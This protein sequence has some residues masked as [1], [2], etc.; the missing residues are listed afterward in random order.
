MIPAVSVAPMMDRTDRHFRWMMRQIAPRVL[1]WS[2]MV[3]TGAVLHGDREK[4]LGHAP[5]EGPVVLQLGGDDPRALAEAAR[6]GVD[7]GYDEI[8]LNCGCPSDRVQQGAF[9]AVL[10]KTPE[11]VAEAV[12]AM[13]AAVD[14]PVTVKHRIGVD[15]VD[16]YA[17]MLHFVDTVAAAG[18]TRFTVHARKAWLQGLSPK[19]NRTIPPL[20]HA[21]VHRLKAERPALWIETNGGVRTTSEAREHLAHVDAV[22]I[23]RGAVDVPWWIGELDAEL[24]DGPGPAPV[25]HRAELVERA[26]VYAEA[27]VARGEPHHRLTRHLL[28]LF[29]GQPGAR[30]W[31]RHLTEGVHAPPGPLLREALRAV[32]AV[33]ARAEEAA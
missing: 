28:T 10:M 4:V 18:C 29:A 15:D 3:T 25:A 33:A 1:L 24:L 23:G 8:N 11:R 26:I 31:K 27:L 12:A 7:A 21:E 16:T 5:D 9:G 20:R 13:R 17:H 32:E 14:V 2:E 6:I 22:M 19:E 30:V